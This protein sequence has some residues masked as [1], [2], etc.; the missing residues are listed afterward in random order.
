MTSFFLSVSV[1]NAD[2]PNASHISSTCV[3]KYSSYMCA[4]I[5]HDGA[6]FMYCINVWLELRTMPTSLN[7]SLMSW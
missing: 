5:S 3:L 4:C 1:S 7:P 6:I 2:R